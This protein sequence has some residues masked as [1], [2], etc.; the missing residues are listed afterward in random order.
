MEAIKQA[1]RLAIIHDPTGSAF[2]VAPVVKQNDGTVISVEALQNRQVRA[3]AAITAKGDVTASSCDNHKGFIDQH[4]DA[5]SRELLLTRS[6]IH[7][8]RLMQIDAERHN[9]PCK[10]Q[11]IE[12]VPLEPRLPPPRPVIPDFVS[13]PDGEKDW[14]QLWDL[15]DQQLEK[16]VIR[17]RNR[18]AA[19]RKALRLKQQDGKVERRAS[20]DEKRRS[21][22]EIKLTW[23]SIKGKFGHA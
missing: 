16:R 23:K 7:P 6:G 3:A 18:K 22:R 17:E 11:E 19:E 1:Q 4:C 2:N 15:D 14:I 21:Y 12:V 8:Q 9:A 10:T 20:R 13:I 5:S